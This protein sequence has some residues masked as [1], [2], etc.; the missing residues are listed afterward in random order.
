[1]SPEAADGPT[2][3][4]VRSATPYLFFN[5]NAAQALALY[6]R[7]LGAKVEGLQRYGDAPDVVQ[8]AELDKERVMHAFVRIGEA[9]L[10]VSDVPPNM[11]ASKGGS[12]DLTEGPPRHQ[13]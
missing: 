5:G 9:T 8:C 1:M 7:T 4:T 11:T 6:E 12:G 3:M 10:M 13:R 2:T